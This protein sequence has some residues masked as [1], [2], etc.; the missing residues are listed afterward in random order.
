[1]S[2]GIGLASDHHSAGHGA[3]APIALSIIIAS[4]NTREI[5]ANCL[6]SIYRSPPADPYEIIVVDDASRDGTSEMVRERFPGVR[7]LR[8]EVNRHYALSNNRAIEQARGQY[9]LLLNSDTV[10]LPEAL[11]R[12]IGFLRSH[13]KAGGVGCRLLNE[14]G[15]IQWSVKSLP[16]PGSALFGATSLASRLFPNNPFTRK[17]LLQVGRDLTTPFAV[18][19]GYLSGASFMSP[20]EAI[21]AVGYLEASLFYHV[22]ADYCKRLTEAGYQCWYLPT[23]TVIHL[24][25]KGGTTSGVRRRFRRLLMFDL[26]SY[27]YYRKHARGSPLS[28]MQILVP[29]GLFSHFVMSASAQAWSELVGALR[30][31]SHFGK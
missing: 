31:L 2:A 5:L 4:Y 20:R 28:P 22:D 30:S 25:H 8:N 17:H 16:N 9:L 6:Q 11:D 26:D 29:L 19:D 15:T 24:N 21:E 23:A 1:M 7:L 18:P 13:P 10:V 27:I 14:D 3:A 12:M